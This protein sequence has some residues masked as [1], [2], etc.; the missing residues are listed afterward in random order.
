ML[1]LPFLTK[2][3]LFV[4][5][6]TLAY[7]GRRPFSLS[8]LTAFFIFYIFSL[9]FLLIWPFSFLLPH[10]HVDIYLN[11]DVEKQVTFAQYKNDI[12]SMED[13]RFSSL[14]AE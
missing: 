6:I 1:L 5:I 3:E 9:H 14:M 7:A 4:L 2:F 13:V 12:L 8:R 10:N 11:L